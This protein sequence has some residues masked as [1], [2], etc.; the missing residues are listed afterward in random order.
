MCTMKQETLDCG[1]NILHELRLCNDFLGFVSCAC[2]RLSN[3]SVVDHCSISTI[4]F[5]LTISGLSTRPVPTTTAPGWPPNPRNHRTLGMRLSSEHVNR[6]ATA[7]KHKRFV[8]FVQ[9]DDP[10]CKALSFLESATL[11]TPET[12]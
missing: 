12:P 9:F 2:L 7:P 6:T 8:P 3:R 1:K 5:S 11:P 10:S 4:A